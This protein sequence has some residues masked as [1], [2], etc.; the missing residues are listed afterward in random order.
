MIASCVGVDLVLQRRHLRAK[1]PS[2]SS[3]VQDR[4]AQHQLDLVGEPEHRAGRGVQRQRRLVEQRRV[5]MVEARRLAARLGVGE[6]PLE[7]LRRL[8]GQRQEDDGERR[9]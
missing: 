1:R 4:L 2:L 5:E 7:E 3:K 9:G 6:Q 8:A